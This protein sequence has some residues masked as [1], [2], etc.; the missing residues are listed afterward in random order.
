MLLSRRSFWRE[1]ALTKGDVEYR[2]KEIQ[3][4]RIQKAIGMVENR[5][6]HEIE[7]KSLNTL[8]RVLS[9]LQVIAESE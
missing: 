4:P 7:E 9:D 2:R 6:T 3:D 1:E 5:I 8:T